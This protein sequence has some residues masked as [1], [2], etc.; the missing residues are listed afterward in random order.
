VVSIEDLPSGFEA[1]PDDELGWLTEGLEETTGLSAEGVFVFLEAER[2]EFVMGFTTLIRNRI[3]QAGFDLPLSRPDLLTEVFVGEFGATDII[4][5]EAEE[6]QDLDDIG[7]AS[8]GIAMLI[9]MEGIPTRMDVAL[10][11][12]GIVGA[13]V[14]HMYIEGEVPV[15]EVD[16]VARR[17]D[18][19]I[20][21]VLPPND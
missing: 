1:I 2:F 12:R 16:D 10:F 7:D 4:I 13:F 14:Y 15:V 20:G 6:L 3:E 19:R 18:A 5:V 17:L 9:D 11:R 21:E 8:A